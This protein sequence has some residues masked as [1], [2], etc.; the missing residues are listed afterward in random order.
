MDSYDYIIVGAGSAGSVL[1]AR[2]T[3]DARCRVLLLEAGGDRVSLLERIPRGWILL[4]ADP[5]YTWSFPVEADGSGPDGE[6]WLRGR[7]LGG[8]SRINGMVYSR[9]FPLD[10]EAWSAAAGEG[11][12]WSEIQ[13]C[14]AAIEDSYVTPGDSTGGPFALGVR[15]NPLPLSEAAIAAGTQLGLRRLADLNGAEREGI[16]YV[17]HGIDRRGRRSSARTAFLAPA[18]RRPNLHIVTG[19]QASR[20]LFEGARAT[21]I[22]AWVDGV[23]R[24]F[25]AQGEV[26]LCCGALHTPQLL[27]VSGIGPGALLAANGI[28]VRR[29]APAV[30]ANL[31]E[32]LVMAM[33]HRLHNAHGHN[34]EFRGLRL[35][36]HAL[37]Y[38]F[39]GRGPLGYGASEVGGFVRS[40]PSLDAPDIQLGMSPYSFDLKRGN[41]IGRHVRTERAPG[42]TFIGTMIRPESRGTLR[43]ASPDMREMPTIRPNWLAT[44]GDQATAV[45]LVCFLRQL[46]RQPALQP[47]IGDEISPG[48]DVLSDA[49]I[50][51]AVRR[52]LASG[53]HTTGTCRMGRDA[54]AV[55]D[56]DLRVRGIEGL[57]IADCSVIP[58]PISGNTNA[59]A[60]AVGW[61]A[62]GLLRGASN[63]ACKAVP[64]EGRLSR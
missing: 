11:W 27:Q 39:D 28:A 25:H 30:G 57:R 61:R 34:R 41:W 36:G 10:Y 45:R 43:I 50:L 3:E 18:R 22:E 44:D 58:V 31:I 20:I 14:F 38:A 40:S 54:A 32:H 7:G 16:G 42:Y 9:G 8:S 51:A 24:R 60:M 59:V 55:V 15:C 23:P 5:D 6:V 35:L 13:R 52:R 53:L 21:G 37:R 64:P 29:D 46:V 62:A 2:L 48:A 56:A 4:R 26:V 33:P 63:A 12:G 1:A 47:Y 19:A 17:S 49:A